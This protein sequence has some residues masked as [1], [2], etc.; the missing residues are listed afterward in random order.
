VRI[1]PL[2][3]VPLVVCKEHVLASVYKQVRHAQVPLLLLPLLL[4]L[5]RELLFLNQRMQE[6]LL[7]LFQIISL[8]THRNPAGAPYIVEVLGSAPING[9]SLV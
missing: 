7:T 5:L 4:L 1:V 3:A 8:V 2:V 6:L 9:Y